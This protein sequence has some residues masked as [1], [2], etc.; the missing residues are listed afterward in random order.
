LIF[1]HELL[2]EFHKIAASGPA[3]APIVRAQGRGKPGGFRLCRFPGMGIHKNR[4]Y[5]FRPDTL[6]QASYFDQFVRPR[7]EGNIRLAVGYD[8]KNG[9]PGRGFKFFGAQKAPGFQKAVRKGGGP[10]RRKPAQLFARQMYAGSGGQKYLR[11]L[12]A[13]GHK[14]YP[15]PPYIGRP[16]KGKH[17][18]LRGG[19]LGAGV[20]GIRGIHKKKDKS[21]ASAYTDFFPQIAGQYRGIRR[22]LFRAAQGGRL[23]GRAQGGIAYSFT[24][25]GKGR[26]DKTPPSAYCRRG[27]EPSPPRVFPAQA[28]K[29]K[30][31]VKGYGFL[32]AAGMRSF[33]LR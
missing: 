3:Q 19:K 4:P 29:L 21:R 1:C 32:V 33:F 11:F 14:P 31:L 30:A 25:S 28:G 9:L 6:P 27:S 24:R 15:V 13:K 18:A 10:S 17:R 20:H 22:R 8:Y 16:Q 26:A 12:P 7:Y 2:Q 23:E 5:S